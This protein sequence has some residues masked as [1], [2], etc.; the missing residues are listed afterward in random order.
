[1]S[2][3]QFQI[4]FHFLVTSSHVPFLSSFPLPFSLSLNQKSSSVLSCHYIEAHMA[5]NWGSV[6]AERHIGTQA[7]SPNGILNHMSQLG[8][9]S[10]SNVA[11]FEATAAPS[12]IPWGWGTKLICAWFPH[13]Q[14]N[15]EVLNICVLQ[16]KVLGQ[17]SNRRA[18]DNFL[19]GLSTSPCPSSLPFALLLVSLQ[20]HW[21]PFS[22]PLD[23]L[24]SVSECLKQW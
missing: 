14:K 8:R 24:A 19:P 4:V 21:L 6:Q 11:S 10:S 7:L 13:P 2:K 15:C 3:F 18:T 23:K 20:P 22:P 12:D 17:C 1:M 5:E 9:K 16:C